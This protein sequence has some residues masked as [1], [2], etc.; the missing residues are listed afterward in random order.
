[1]VLM[2][3]DIKRIIDSQENG[4]HQ[5]SSQEQSRVAG[6][7][8]EKNI[9]QDADEGESPVGTKSVFRHLLMAVQEFL[10]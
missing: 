7:Y 8:A 5:A 1:M 4:Q 2:P 9:T 10:R 3:L 6:Q